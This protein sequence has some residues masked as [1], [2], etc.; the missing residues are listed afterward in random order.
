MTRAVTRSLTILELLAQSAT[1]LELPEII[2]KTGIA[3]ATA[4]R[5]MASLVVDGYVVR[6]LDAHGYRISFRFTGIAA[7]M[8]SGL[9]VRTVALPNMIDLAMALQHAVLLGFLEGHEIW[10]TDRIEVV[11]DRVSPVLTNAHAPA[12]SSA[13]GRVIAAY[14]LDSTALDAMISTVTA[15]TSHTITDPD[16]LRAL[17]HE[18]ANRGYAT[19][20][21][22]LYPDASGV[23]APIFGRDG[24][25]VAAMSLPIMGA[26]SDSA[27]QRVVAALLAATRRTSIELGHRSTEGHRV[28]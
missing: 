23:A 21:R 1:S 24:T 9:E 8:L 19:M 16:R 15:R 6:D 27:V 22:E 18:A 11:G 3:R 17:V 25:A 13:S 4:H 20:D 14:R 5:M 12:I 7:S 2:E 26:L 10:G 28:A